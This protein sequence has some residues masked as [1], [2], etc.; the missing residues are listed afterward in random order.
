[1]IFLH[2]FDRFDPW[3]CM[4]HELDGIATHARWIG[5]NRFVHKFR[6]KV[7]V[8]RTEIYL[9]IYGHVIW[10]GMG[11]GHGFYISNE[12]DHTSGLGNSKLLHMFFFK[13]SS[14]AIRMVCGGE[15]TDH[16]LLILTI[17]YVNKC[18]CCACACVCVHATP[19]T[20]FN[21]PS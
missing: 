16:R 1:M 2:N 8:E 3:T 10:L 12:M 19:P 17:L 20:T 18:Y 14:F 5:G 21:A 9:F 11:N 6:W 13:S 15:K 4:I 7:P